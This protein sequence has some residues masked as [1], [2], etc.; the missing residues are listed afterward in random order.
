M[1][2]DKG[3]RTVFEFLFY[4]FRDHYSGSYTKRVLEEAVALLGDLWPYLIAGILLTS[5]IKMFLPKEK[6]A[7]FFNHRKNVPILLAAALGVVAPLG[8]YVVIPLTASL[9]ML[10][11]PLPVL[12]ALLVSSP[13][14]DPNLF[15]L[16]AGAFGYELAL[17]RLIAAFLLGIA[18]GY[19]T[20]WLMQLA[21]IKETAIL[22]K[23]TTDTLLIP[24][25]KEEKKP[26]RSFFK[27]LWSMTLYIC[28]YFSL[29]IILAALI[30]I[31]TPPNLMIELFNDNDFLSVLFTTAAGIPFYS[32][33]GAAIPVVLEL[34]DMGLSQGA[35]LAFF[36]AGPVTKL[37]NLVLLYAAYNL[38][39]FM[40][41]IFTGISGALLFGWFYNIL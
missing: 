34:A 22:K 26:V 8:S 12:M 36:I 25:K 28:K 4:T 29:A 6:I 7:A 15:I 40:V 32:C 27:A 17:A 41:Y 10:G 38:R 39:I 11:T 31:L 37:S 16:T 35:V 13:L 9:F 21:F 18:A 2:S 19:F 23:E 14:I 30:K 1:I 33:G 3:F 24:M 20:Q 5:F